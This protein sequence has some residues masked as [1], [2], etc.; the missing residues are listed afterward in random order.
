MNAVTKFE[1]VGVSAATLQTNLITTASVV[2]DNVTITA[3]LHGVYI[4]AR[5]ISHTN[6]LCIQMINV[7]N[8][9]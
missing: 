6:T 4:C 8:K 5:R 2:S 1:R 3:L 7:N 9:L